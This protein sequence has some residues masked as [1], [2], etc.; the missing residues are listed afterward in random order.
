MSQL[1]RRELKKL[2]KG[3]PVTANVAYNTIGSEPEYE[4][5]YEDMDAGQVKEGDRRS[6]PPLPQDPPVTPNMAY[7]MIGSMP[8][9]EADQVNYPPQ[10][11]AAT[12]RDS[13]VSMYEYV[14]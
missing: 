4:A 13:Y 7:N 12:T 6:R 3:P 14:N 2:P 8:E 1:D 10:H 11:T 5:V 9:Y